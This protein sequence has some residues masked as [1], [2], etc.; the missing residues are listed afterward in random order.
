MRNFFALVLFASFIRSVLR[1]RIVMLME[2]LCP[3]RTLEIMPLAST[4]TKTN[5]NSKKDRTFHHRLY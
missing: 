3:V 5:K 1:M 4:E 2:L